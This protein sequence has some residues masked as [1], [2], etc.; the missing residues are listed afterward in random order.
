MIKESNHESFVFIQ[1]QIS[2][3]NIIY[4][5]ETSLSFLRLIGR[6][7]QTKCRN[8]CWFDA[9]FGV[10]FLGNKMV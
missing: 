6:D 10:P 9:C 3:T 5:Y 1:P 8:I 2:C 4:V 7:K